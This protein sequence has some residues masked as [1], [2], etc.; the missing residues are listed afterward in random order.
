MTQNTGG[1]LDS[2][3]APPPNG[4]SARH[5]VVRLWGLTFTHLRPIDA[6]DFLLSAARLARREGRGAHVHLLNS[7]SVVAAHDD[8]QL[9]KRL[10]GNAINLI[11]GTPLIWLARWHGLLSAGSRA[12]R[13]PELFVQTLAA[14]VPAG[15]K[16]YLLGGSPEMLHL[17]ED[18]LKRANPELRIVGALSPPFRS[19]T[20]GERASAVE[21]IGRSGADIVWVGLGTPKQDHEAAVLANSL[22]VLA[23]A[24]GAA[25][26]FACGAKREAPR[27]LRHSGFEWAFRLLTEPKR[28]WK[29][30]LIGNARFLLL[31][32]RS[33]RGR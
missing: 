29:R 14:G 30:Y 1:S 4:L 9:A 13:G 8:P 17:L 15:I 21:E 12:T 19:W 2:C 33:S 7:Y 26:D 27:L 11:D 18:S 20:A 24:V 16:H 22:P 5:M 6:P 28:L 32:L 31:A 25:F 3:V 10:T 23:V